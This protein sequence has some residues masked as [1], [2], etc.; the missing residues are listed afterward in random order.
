MRV[1]VCQLS[2]EPGALERE[3]EA[4]TAHTRAERS[5]LVL[6]PEMPFHPW[7][8][9]IRPA[10]PAAWRAAVAAHDRWLE[11]LDEL[12][13][14]CVLGTR[15]V[16]HG[17]GR[18]NEGFSWTR[19]AGLHAGR[20]KHHLPDEPGFW[21][22]SWY[23]RGDADFPLLRAA[24]AQVGFLICTELWF[25]E[26][27]R[28][29][30]RSGAHLLVCPRATPAATLDKWIAGGRAAAVV[31]GA[32]CLSSGLAGS[33]GG[34]SFGGGGWIVEPEEGEL[35]GVT[36][37]ERPFLTLE[38]DLEAAERAKRTYPRYVE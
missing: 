33:S 25:F 4:L 23:G 28:A 21:E 6:L 19:E 34:V 35:L 5:D 10:D 17:P 38:I 24:N 29:Y 18:R 9:G 13:A 20:A 32:W 36:S 30:G 31:A 3:W 8:C 16:S 15:P 26:R 1:S 14:S 22:A 11:R 12:G 7:L 37:A 2:P 27:A